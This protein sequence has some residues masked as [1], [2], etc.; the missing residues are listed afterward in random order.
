[1]SNEAEKLKRTALNKGVYLRQGIWRGP[2]ADN[3]DFVQNEPA[4]R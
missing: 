2:G 1:M 4:K 3:L